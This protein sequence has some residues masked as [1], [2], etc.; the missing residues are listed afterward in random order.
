MTPR[1][2]VALLDK[3]YDEYGKERILPMFPAGGRS[4]TISSRY[5]APDGEPPF[6]YAKTG[7]LRNNNALSG[8]I[9]TDSGRRLIFSF[10][11]NNFVAS[12]NAVITEMEKVLNLIKKH[13]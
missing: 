5:R 13:Y 3:L 7:T 6:V 1:S 9:Y 11:N 10:V 4:G 12:S 2:I 8:Y